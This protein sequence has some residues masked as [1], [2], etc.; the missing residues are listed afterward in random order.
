VQQHHGLRHLRHEQSDNPVGQPL[1]QIVQHR[2]ATAPAGAPVRRK[3]GAV[4]KGGFLVLGFG[5]GSECRELY[6]IL[7]SPHNTKPHQLLAAG[8]V[9]G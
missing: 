9:D 2:V 7:A 8:Q 6:L 3:I 1:G 5:G 4:Q